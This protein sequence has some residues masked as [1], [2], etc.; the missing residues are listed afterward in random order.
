[1]EKSFL[2]P[3]RYLKGIGPKKAKAF[4]KLGIQTIED[5]LYYFPRR[6][7]DRTNFVPIS[8][9]KEGQAMT[10]KAQ[11]LAKGERRSWRR[12]PVKSP[13]ATTGLPRDAQHFTWR[14]FS[15]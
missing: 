12:R 1:M 3:V 6:Y 15:I 14:A 13:S 2:S 10:T 4:N 9:L 8:K 7:E 11:I 5:L